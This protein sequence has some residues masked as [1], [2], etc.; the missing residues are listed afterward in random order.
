MWVGMGEMRRGGWRDVPVDVDEVNSTSIAGFQELG[1]PA[2]TRGV[3]GCGI[4]NSG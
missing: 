4:S 3:G 1:Q 2:Q